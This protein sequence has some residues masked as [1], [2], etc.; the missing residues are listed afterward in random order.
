MNVPGTIEGNWH[1]RFAWP[2]VQPEQ[3]TRLKTQLQKHQRYHTT[4]ATQ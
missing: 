3:L 1:W 2:Q 4:A